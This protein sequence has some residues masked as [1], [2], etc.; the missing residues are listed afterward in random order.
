MEETI[1]VCENSLEG[2]LTAI[3]RAYEWKLNPLSARVQVGEA[4][5]CLFAVYREVET[6]AALA[7]KVANTVRRRSGE[8]AWESV[9]YALASE[10]AEKGQAVYQTIA[11]GLSGQIRGPL[12]GGLA[13]EHIRKT[14][15]LSRH[16][17]NEA[18]RMKEFLRF[19]ELEGRVLFAQI[20]PDANVLEFIMPHFADR[21]PLENFVI[22]DSRRGIA[23]IHASSREWFLVRMNEGVHMAGFDQQPGQG[24]QLKS[25]AEHYSREELEMAELFRHFCHTIGIKE[26]RNLKLQQQFLPLKY[27][28]FMTEFE[29]SRTACIDE[30]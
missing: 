23:G 30:S 11:A 9:C 29:N 12:M 27:R 28:S 21:F 18:H 19:K 10:D 4:D 3:Y 5:L 1:L 6:N 22:M 16:V 24:T 8:E 17:H 14:F 2:V 25:V 26:R 7:A 15:E 13:N 20:E